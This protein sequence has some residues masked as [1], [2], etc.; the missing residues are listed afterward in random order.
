MA[1]GTAAYGAGARIAHALDGRL[2]NVGPDHVCSSFV[3][4]ERSYSLHASAQT[5]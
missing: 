1:L 4:D 5:Q 2:P 3:A